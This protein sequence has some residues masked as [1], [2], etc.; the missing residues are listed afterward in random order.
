MENTSENPIDEL[1]AKSDYLDPAKISQPAP[2]KF[3]F[4]EP[5]PIITPVYPTKDNVSGV[6]PNYYPSQVQQNSINDPVGAAKARLNNTIAKMDNLE[7]RNAYGYA[8]GFDSSPKNTSRDRYKAYGQETYNK[9]G[10]NPLINN[11]AWF[12]QN[13]TFGD[14]LRRFWTHAAWPMLSKGFMDPIKSYQSVING[15]G[16]FHA[17]EQSARDYEYYNSIGQSTK[18]GLGG[19]TVNLLTSASYSMGI[20]LEGVLES[21]IIEGVAG[22]GNPITAVAGGA[23]KFISRMTSLP[24]SM[25]EGAK[26]VTKLAQ[27]M[28]DYSKIN[29]AKELFQSAGKNFVNFANP[30]ANTTRSLMT[31][32][33]DN[34]ASLARASSTPGALWHD[35]MVMNLALSEGKLEG[36]FT[37]YQTYDKLYNKFMSDPINEGRAPSLKEQEDMM[38]EAAKGSFWNTLNNTALIFY[39]NKLVFPSLTNASFVKGMP[40]FGFGNILGDLNKEY[41]LVFRPGKN[42]AQGAFSKEKIGIVNAIKSLGRPA[43]YGKVGLNYFKANVVEGLQESIQ[44]VLQEATQNYYVDTYKNPAAKNFSYAT[45]LIGDAIGKQMSAQ[46]AET[47]FSGF[48]M[49]SIL[50]APSKIKSY[51]TMGYNDYFNKSAKYKEYIEQR[52]S[53]ANEVVEHMNTMWKNSDLFFDPRMT[54][55]SIQSLLYNTVSNPD[56]KTTKEIKDDRFTAFQT[57]VISSLQ[58]GTFNMFLDHYEKYKQATPQDIEEAWNL[59]PGQGAK[60]LE[61]FSESLEN[62]K[63]VKYRYEQAKEKMKFLANLDDYDKDGYKYKMAKIYNSAYMQSLFNFVFLQGAYDDA[64]GR[65]DKLYKKLSSISSI[66]NSNFAEFA[67]F[68]DPVRLQREIEMMKTEVETL[69]Q[70]DI[71]TAASEIN[72]KKEL[73]K[74]YSAFKEKQDNILNAFINKTKLSALSEAILKANPGLTKEQLSLQTFDKLIEQYDQGKSNEFTEYKESFKNLLLGLAKNQDEQ[75]EV[76]RQIDAMDKGLDGLFDDLLDTHILKHEKN[77]IVPLINIL[78]NPGDFYDHLLRNFQWMRNLYYNRKNVIKDIVNTEITNIERNALLNA[79]AD[80]GI[81]VDLEEFAKWVEDPMYKPEYFIDEKNNTIIKRGGLLYDEYYKLFEK[82]AELEAVKPA[83]EPETDSERLQEIIDDITEDRDNKIKVAREKFDKALKDKY[84]ATEKE[85]R[86]LAKKAQEAGGEDLKVYEERL[87]YYQEI[88]EQ[89]ETLTNIEVTLGKLVKSE[90][91]TNEQLIEVANI[92]LA[93]EKYDNDIA[94]LKAKIKE[95]NP[96][97]DDA[98]SI[99]RAAFYLGTKPLIQDFIKEQEDL[100]A[101]FVSPDFIDVEKTEEWAQYQQELKDINAEFEELIKEAKLEF[102]ESG[103]NPTDVRTYTVDDRFEDFPEDLKQQLTASFDSFLV[104]NLQED[105]SI[106][107]DKPDMYMSLR[108]RWQEE[109]PDAAEIIDKYNTKIKEEAV[110]NSTSGVTPP[111]L[112]YGNVSIDPSTPLENLTDLYIKYEEAVKTKELTTDSN[113]K[114]A[115]TPEDIKNIREDMKAIAAYI[116]NKE[117]AYKLKPLAQ[118]VIERL[119][120]TIFNRQNELE[121][122]VD[123]D[124]FESRRFK[125]SQPSDPRPERATEV[126]AQIEA[127]IEEKDPFMYNKL[128]D[129]TIQN[130]FQEIVLNN[131]IGTVEER[132]DAFLVT[133][134]NYDQFKSDQKIAKIK[135]SLLND[136]TVENLVATVNNYVFS[137]R[138]T[139][140]VNIDAA[141]RE[142]LTLDP[143]GGFVQL[144]YSSTINLRGVKTKISDI[145]SE[146]AYNYLFHPI[147]GFITRFRRNMIDNELQLFSNNVKVF[148]R[149]ARDGRGVTGELDLLLIDT[150]GNLYVVD[151]K[152]AYENTWRNLGAPFALNKKG[153]EVIVD[154]EK[155][156]NKGN[157]KTYFTAQQSIYR[158]SIYNMSGLDSSL[159]LLPIEMKVTLDGYIQTL[160]YPTPDLSKYNKLTESGMFI[161]LEPLDDATMQKYGFQRLAPEEI[162]SLIP[163]PSEEEEIVPED[164]IQVSDPKKQT[165]NQFLNQKVIYQGKVGTLVNNLDGGF[166]LEIEE[167]DTLKLIDINFSGKNVKDG[168]T[169]IVTVGVAPIAQV[170]VVGQVTQVNGTTINARFLDKN[171]STAEIDGVKYTVNRDSTGAIVSL[172][173]YINDKEISEVQ[174]KINEVNTEINNLQKQKKER[175]NKNIERELRKK[176]FELNRLN[177]LKTDLVNKNKKRTRRGGNTDDLIFALNRLPNKFQKQVSSSEPTDRENQVKLIAQLSESEAVTKELDRILVEHG[178]TK[179]VEDVFD[180]KIDN[181]TQTK[182]DEIEEWGIGLI[183]KLEEYQSRLTN[184]QRSTVPVD[185]MIATVNEILNNLSLI[186]FFKNGK[187]TK[188][189]RK[190]F[191]ARTKVQQGTNV[192]P[193]QKSTGTTAEGVSRQTISRED[194]Q[195]QIQE[196]RQRIQGISLGTTAPVSDETKT[197]I[198][199]LNQRLDAYGNAEVVLSSDFFQGKRPE[200]KL[201]GFK[202][203][204]SQIRENLVVLADVNWNNFDF[205]LSKEDIE[206][207]NAL[208]SLAEEL[209]TINTLKISSRDTRTVAVEKRFAQLTNQLANEFV[210]IIGKHVEQ[211]LGKTITSS[212][213]RLAALGTTSTQPT[214][215]SNRDEI[216]TEVENFFDQSTDNLATTFISA[217]LKFVFG[218][219]E[220]AYSEIVDE[221]YN[222]RLQN[223]ENNILL[224]NLIEGEPLL[225]KE[226]VSRFKT[227]GQIFLVQTVD[228]EAGNAVLY[229]T[230]TKKSYTFTE[231]VIKESFMRPS[232]EKKSVEEMTV[233]P[234]TKENVNGTEANITNLSKDPDALAKIEEESENLTPEE[235]M[236]KIKNIFNKC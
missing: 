154:G 194:L 98:A 195:K 71:S 214:E 16:F 127:D 158:N 191:E 235:I 30:L 18:G 13:T 205:F 81:F 176:T 72:R 94:E 224:E 89:L 19:F 149:T 164:A 156:K 163:T 38:K 189:S 85:L 162:E 117:K 138:S 139:A 129:N 34:F 60:A 33:F 193:I 204:L 199:G 83:G 196:A 51:M 145:M 9:V 220:G 22:G 27:T 234:Q 160:K 47:F 113:K 91:I 236:E 80:Q 144:P 186:K 135:E 210:D 84:D 63:K 111:K 8:F 169:N 50:Q 31:H 93:D 165:L 130:V 217:V 116:Q 5:H 41:Q 68:T 198:E 99:E 148:D 67:G 132:L 222:E 75:I 188:T 29:K 87:A 20:L 166:S 10:F 142:F 232:D 152:A 36:G 212:K 45:G 151:I 3:D 161:I 133:L 215:G 42:V 14:D 53:E 124:G 231:E 88:L 112:L 49:G 200:G 140:G 172:T 229:N 64:A 114:V 183:I 109:Q 37:K 4:N 228:L 209:D 106:K 225:N 48:L 213:P 233:T 134:R 226:P 56:E 207:L 123:E 177:S 35:I 28:N 57:A 58:R 55:Y 182:L 180:G 15:D 223:I 69:E 39:S 150:E 181:L 208:K 110:K 146:E 221:V 201:N 141:I 103:G 170:E 143:K 185:N 40:K 184:E 17:D 101:N 79:L 46:G 131:N 174:E 59:A 118:E 11:E 128:E 74:L 44:D 153:Q 125:D 23:G 218:Q 54:N 203:V 167:D 32:N 73:L 100:I 82:A 206:K 107:D 66:K 97:I 105:I 25:Y 121:I 70:T 136:L 192:S 108:Q 2:I 62:A 179:D 78:S 65:L 147:T 173:Y 230:K 12:N 168:N 202:S 76:Q 171:D 122:V 92:I 126:A 159:L 120:K 21:A 61:N 190:E 90:D 119:E 137:E 155:V 211:Q 52:E 197:P 6:S 187:I 86:D 43:S 219:T 178:T 24:R 175:P 227:I 102:L 77:Q 115:L 95:V 104:N 96:E 157:K 216:K 1:A 26:G 7:D